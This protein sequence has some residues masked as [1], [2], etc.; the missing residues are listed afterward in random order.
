[1]GKIRYKINILDALKQAGY[2]T[3][4]IRKEQ[5]FGESHV[6]AFRAGNVVYGE[7]TMCRLC[8]LLNCQPGD[9]LEYVPETTE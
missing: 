7:D 3:Y 2:S 6:Q 5:I 9:I 1:M 8:A 4:R